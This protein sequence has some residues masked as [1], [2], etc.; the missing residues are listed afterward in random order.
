MI[1]TYR[2]LPTATAPSWWA[3]GKWPTTAVSTSA[4]SGTDR[5]DR[6]MGTASAQTRRWVGAWR[7]AFNSTDI[8]HSTAVADYNGCARGGH[9][10]GGESPGQCADRC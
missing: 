5:L 8:G 6:I 4:T 2:V 10:W 3:W 1:S 7:Q 9:A